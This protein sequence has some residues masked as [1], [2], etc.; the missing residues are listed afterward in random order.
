[1]KGNLFQVP[2]YFA[3]IAKAFGVLEGIG[4]KSDPDYAIVGEC[5]PY[6]SQRLLTDT[7]PR[8]G[9][10]LKNFIF[11]KDEGEVDRVIDIERVELLFEGFSSYASS[12]K[13][14]SESESGN[15]KTQPLL[16]SGN[17]GQDE[18]ELSVEKIEYFSDQI[19]NLLF[20]NSGSLSPSS[21][22]SR[23]PLQRLVIEEASKIIGALTRQ[24]WSNL[25]HR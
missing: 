5:L 15:D 9:A 23:T 12:T 4:L 18:K 7:N 11:G 3:Y 21:F 10:A 22:A 13:S 16:L 19:I 1:M 2:P 14:N 6:V 24:Q 20:A 17:M 8:T 25:R